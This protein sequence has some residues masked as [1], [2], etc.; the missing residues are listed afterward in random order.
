MTSQE[1][2]RDKGDTTARGGSNT[3]KG[4]EGRENKE[5]SRNCQS[6]V[7]RGMGGGGCVLKEG[8]RGK[9]GS[10]QA[11]GPIRLGFDSILKALRDSVAL[12]SHFVCCMENRFGRQS[13]GL[14]A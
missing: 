4:R 6:V 5:H 7:Q 14:V 13:G 11:K 10:G 12:E 8:W 3:C 2:L 1:E 9:Q